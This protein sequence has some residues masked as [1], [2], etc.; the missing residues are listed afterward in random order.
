MAMGC[1]ILFLMYK[2]N[3]KVIAFLI[4]I[5]HILFIFDSVRKFFNP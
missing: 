5:R 4:N 2:P 3:L 1:L